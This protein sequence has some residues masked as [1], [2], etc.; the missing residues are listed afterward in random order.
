MLCIGYGAPDEGSLSAETY[1][2]PGSP[3]LRVG[4]PPSPTRG[5]G[6]NNYAPAVVTPPSTTMVWPVMKV[7]ASE[8][9]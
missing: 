8:A 6:K 3:P 2:S 7:E 1:P 9:R 5:E 4:D